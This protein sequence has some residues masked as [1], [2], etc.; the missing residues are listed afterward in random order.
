M[1]PYVLTFYKLLLISLMNVEPIVLLIDVWY[2]YTDFTKNS[3]LDKNI[4]HSG[5]ID[6]CFDG[7]VMPGDVDVMWKSVCQVSVSQLVLVCYEPQ[8][9]PQI[10]SPCGSKCIER[11]CERMLH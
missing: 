3:V 6:L 5:S 11:H 2:L 7:S 8:F 10:Y 9:I 4:L 1:L